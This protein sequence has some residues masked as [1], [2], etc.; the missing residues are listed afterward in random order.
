V[1]Q[2]WPE[3]TNLDKLYWP[4]DGF[5]KGHA[6]AFYNFVGPT[7]VPY[8]ADRPM[9]LERHPNGIHGASF[10]HKNLEHAPAWIRK[11]K[12]Y[13]HDVERDVH[14][15][16]VDNVSSLLYCI[17]LGA[18]SLSPWS[19]RM[20]ALTSPDFAILDLD[21]GDLCPFE[22]VSE[23]AWLC[24]AVLD[25]IGLRG[26]PK[27]SGAT[28]LH[29]KVPLEPRYGYEDAR[30]LCEAIARVVEARRPDL[31]TTVRSVRDRPQERVYLDYLQ[32][33]QGKTIVCEYALR[34]KPH[35]PVSTP[36]VWDEVRFGLRP[37][38][39]NIVTFP[40]RLLAVGDLYRPVLQDRQR[41]EDARR[42]VASLL[43]R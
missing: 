21:P 17:Q 31:A 26:Y 15:V 34:A 8:L 41:L 30:L 43:R 22:R 2:P 32:N 6:I 14:Y 33:V 35:A 19:S 12:I 39:W 37:E 3:F 27:T 1:A 42:R 5:T 38:Q 40:P 7:L 36:L 4:E 11:E 9:V 23:V 18:I 28:G 25:E 10:Y 20:S 13:A 29:I 16:I 24:R